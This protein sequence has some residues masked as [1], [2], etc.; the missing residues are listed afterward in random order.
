[1]YAL[2]LLCTARFARWN[3]EIN[4]SIPCIDLLFVKLNLF[5]PVVPSHYFLVPV[6]SLLRLHGLLRLLRVRLLEGHHRGPHGDH[7]PHDGGTR[8]QRARLRHPAHLSLGDHHSRAGL[9]QSR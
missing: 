4:Y 1:M 9:A 2:V 7:G 6:R 8:Q 3:T 5:D